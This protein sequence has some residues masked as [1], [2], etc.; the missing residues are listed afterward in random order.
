[1]FKWYD[2]DSAFSSLSLSLFLVFLS[3]FLPFLGGGYLGVVA[4]S[5]PMLTFY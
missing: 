1:M 5:T 2:R 4:L 3:V